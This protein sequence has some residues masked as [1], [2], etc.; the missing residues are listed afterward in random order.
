MAVTRLNFVARSSR[1]SG[2]RLGLLAGGMLA[3]ASA[4]LNWSLQ[5]RSVARLEASIAMAQPRAVV[6]ASLP[7]AQQ[8]IQDEQE[9]AVGEAVRQLNLPVGRLIRTVQAPQG[10]RV[11]LLGLDLANKPEPGQASAG[12][13][14][15]LKISAEAETP[16]DMMNYVAY[17]N[18]QPLF[19]SVYLVKHEMAA[20]PGHPYR[21][22][23]E[24]VWKE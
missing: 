24:A 19:T 2:W 10:V 21:F 17:L 4:C 8:R 13:S 1:P 6:R 22:Q 5:A 9:K 12:P 20:A 14:G 7:A 11:A 16:Q 3:L 23:M 15:A 18:E